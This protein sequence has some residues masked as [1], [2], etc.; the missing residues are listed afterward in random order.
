MS[1]ILECG[2]PA[3]KASTY[4]RFILPFAYCPIYLEDKKQDCHNDHYETTVLEN[5]ERRR[6]YLT[7]ETADVLFNRARWFKLGSEVFPLLIP[8]KTRQSN[9]IIDVYVN[10]PQ[11][12]LFEFPISRKFCNKCKVNTD[13][14]CW[15]DDHN[16]L[17]IGFLI[18]ETYFSELNGG[19]TIDD[20]LE[21][22]EIFRY[23]Q[24]Y[25]REHKSKMLDH[26]IPIRFGCDKTIDA[27]SSKSEIY[28][29]RWADLL[30]KPIKCENGT[31][32]LFPF[33]WEDE[34][35]KYVSDE[36]TKSPGWAIYSDN[37]T[38]VW[39][40][41]I[42]KNGGNDLRQFFGLPNE[43]PW[44]FGH[45]IKLLN[46]DEPGKDVGETHKSRDFERRW[47]EE[48]TY[49]RWEELGTLY[50]FNYHS[51]AMLGPAINEPPLWE[52]FG[53]M[54]FDQTLLLLYIRVA[55]FRFCMELNKISGKA[56][57]RKG[58]DISIWR[59]EFQRVRWSFALFTNLYQFPSFSNQQQSIEMYN[60]AREYMDIDDLFR[61][62]KEEIDNC[63]EYL[64]TAENIKQ[65]GT[66]ERINYIAAIG[67]V[68]SI[69]IGFWGMNIIVEEN[70][71]NFCLGIKIIFLVISIPVSFGLLIILYRIFSPIL[72]KFFEKFERRRK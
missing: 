21:F 32:R 7:Y 49:K 39:T 17:R 2:D 60:L 19:V 43:K 59:D 27:E 11:L 41:A 40:C 28:F 25:Y 9:K 24:P 55:T 14:S 48:R 23:W 56:V 20:L 5:I 37:R 6:K 46:V 1:I 63:H 50:G 13:E 47:A 34:A 61:E 57:N 30:S 3:K 35:R 26:N 58:T 54:Y 45:W 44:N 62:T 69:V 33:G 22:N 42:T 68:V 16:I 65:S 71:G 51:G 4:T 72:R 12:V 10:K 18:V 8:F 52:H 67:L 66:M 64:T 53:Q 31:F 38:Y 70:F 15:I 36:D 29:D